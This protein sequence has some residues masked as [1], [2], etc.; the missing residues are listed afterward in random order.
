[1]DDYNFEFDLNKP[2]GLKIGDTVRQKF[3]DRIE[4]VLDKEKLYNLENDHL[5][6]WWINF[7]LVNK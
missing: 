1:M 5:G 4:F 2:S 7:E 6:E 3:G